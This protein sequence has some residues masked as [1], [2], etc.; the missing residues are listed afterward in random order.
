MNI[1]L[2]NDCVSCVH[3]N[4]TW[5][6]DFLTSKNT[7]GICQSNNSCPV[8]K[9][10]ITSCISCP[11]FEIGEG[12]NL[13]NQIC[14]ATNCQQCIGKT[15]WIGAGP[16]WCYFGSLANSTSTSGFCGTYGE[17]CSVN[18][19]L[20][21]LEQCPPSS[22]WTT[23]DSCVLTGL[24]YWCNSQ[25]NPWD[26]SGYCVQS[27]ESCMNHQIVVSLRN[28]PNGLLGGLSQPAFI[29]IVTLFSL[30]FIILLLCTVYQV[31]RM[32]LNYIQI[33]SID[34]RI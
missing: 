14:K 3:F 4:G 1:Q 13:G 33:H 9:T 17:S 24:W 28:C 7:A 12:M 15:I 11:L 10:P 5:C 20:I 31:R 18:N 6:A 27:S 23:C 26:T 30:F 32:K 2:L 22:Q 29:A 19:S 25:S 34:N 21:V 16:Q 8:A